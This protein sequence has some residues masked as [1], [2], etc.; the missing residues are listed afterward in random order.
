M[1]PEACDDGVMSDLKG[2]KNDCLGVFPGWTCSGGTSTSAD[3]CSTICG[4]GFM[5]D[6]ETCD[7]SSDDGSGCLTGCTGVA[8]GWNCTHV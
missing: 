5:V 7:D 8:A 1:G 6:T 4:D 2:C 3:S